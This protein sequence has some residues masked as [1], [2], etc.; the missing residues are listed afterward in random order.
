MAKRDDRF[1]RQGINRPMQ[2][3]GA[4]SGSACPGA[5]PSCGTR[6]SARQYLG[7]TATEAYH[8]RDR[9]PQLGYRSEML[10]KY[11]MR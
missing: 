11:H 4:M 7:A 5:P 1:D 8:T 6:P 9:P 2:R 3:D 10:R